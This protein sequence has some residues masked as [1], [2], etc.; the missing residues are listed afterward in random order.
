MSGE[1]GK[2]DIV[3]QVDTMQYLTQ[4]H[5]PGNI[6]ELKNVIQQSLFNMEGNRLSPFDL[7]PELLEGPVE[8]DEKERLIEAMIKEDGNVTNAAKILDISRDTM[9]RKIK[10]I[11]LTAED[12]KR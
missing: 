7:P 2:R 1:F 5:W 11:R 4:Y 9:Y 12:W 10:S 6:R 8:E 3:V